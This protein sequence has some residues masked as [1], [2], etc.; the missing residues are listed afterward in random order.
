MKFR[1]ERRSPI[2]SAVYSSPRGSR[3]TTPFGTSNAASGMSADGHI[4]GHGVLG[5]VA[6]G[7]VRSAVDARRREMQVARRQLNALVGHKH[8]LKVEPF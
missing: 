7:N 8:S 4:A 5:D 3:T 1:T 6:I 2:L